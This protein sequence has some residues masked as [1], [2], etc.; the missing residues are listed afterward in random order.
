MP[1]RHEIS[2]L[3]T[4]TFALGCKSATS[5]NGPPPVVISI[6]PAEV[7]KGV[8]GGIPQLGGFCPTFD[9]NPASVVVGNPI[10]FK[11]LSANEVTIIGVDKTPWTTVPA[12]GTSSPIVAQTV[13][14][15]SYAASSC[16]PLQFVGS[17]F[18]GNLFVTIG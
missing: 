15:V 12:G 3:A 6:G 11:N 4:L 16:G 14:K 1:F 17:Q 18:Y 8:P 2:L 9:P 13:H 5:D 7:Y 10:Q